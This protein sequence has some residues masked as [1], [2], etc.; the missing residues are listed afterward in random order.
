MAPFA[1]SL[2]T[3]VHSPIKGHVW[4]SKVVVVVSVQ[5]QLFPLFASLF[6]SKLPLTTPSTN[7]FN[8]FNIFFLQYLEVFVFILKLLKLINYKIPINPRLTLT[9]SN[10][11]QNLCYLHA[12]TLTIG[13]F[14]KNSYQS[15]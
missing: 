9:I 3:F 2:T 8:Y 1:S 13:L 7:K 5:Q 6:F 4:Y 14:K 11:S 15:I 10:C 12:Y